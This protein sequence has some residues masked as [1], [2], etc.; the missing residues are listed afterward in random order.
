MLKRMKLPI[1]CYHK[2]GPLIEE[3][4]GLN[5]EPETLSHQ[6]QFFK[7]RGYQFIKASELQK[8]WPKRAICLTFDDGYLSTLTYGVET[9]KKHQV[10]AT[11]YVVPAYVGENSYWK[12]AA[13][14]P[15]A[16]W[17]LL[18]DA[19]L[20]GIEISN[21]TY[22]HPY[23]S[24]LS[25]EEQIKE[26]SLAHQALKEHGFCSESFCFPYGF[27]NEQTLQ[28]MQQTSYKIGLGLSRRRATPKDNPLAL[29]RIVIRNSDKLPLLLYTLYLRPHLHHFHKRPHY[30]P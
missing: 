9:L 23:L 10:T 28:A 5:V 18:K 19:R 17:E 8:S 13:P 27:F 24:E 15:L 3:G 16:S 14:R 20:Q 25:L 11:I 29:P 21:H 12:N 26:I 30:I 2:V 7:K 4:R 6:I 22:T 1:L